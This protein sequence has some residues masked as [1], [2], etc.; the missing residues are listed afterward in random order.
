MNHQFFGFVAVLALGAAQ[1]SAVQAA[2]QPISSVPATIAAAG[3][4]C[5]TADFSTAQTSGNLITVN[6]D[7]VTIDFQGHQIDA[8]PGGIY[9]NVTGIYGIDRHNI[10][11]RNGLMVGFYT[12]IHFDTSNNSTTTNGHLIEDMRFSQSRSRAM[13]VEGTNNVIRRNL[14]VD[15]MGGALHPDGFSAC[16]QDANGSIQ[17]YNNTVLHVGGPT[18]SSPDGMMLYCVNTLAIGNRIIDASDQGIGAAGGFC[19]DNV[20][21]GSTEPYWNEY[22]RTMDIP[23]CQLVGNTEFVIE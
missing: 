7:N 14:V 13:Q 10:T 18:D 16:E 19:K 23:G 17:V 4:Y 20:I 5:L 2:C 3:T 1:A 21:I 9:T 11:I 15:T 22:D 8:T 12:G 6:A